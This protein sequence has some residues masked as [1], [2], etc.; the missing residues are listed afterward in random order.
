M[1]L[2]IR[3]FSVMVRKLILVRFFRIE[4][5]TVHYEINYTDIYTCIQSS[6]D[7]ISLS[8]ASKIQV[9]GVPAKV[10]TPAWSEMISRDSHQRTNIAGSCVGAIHI[11]AKCSEVRKLTPIRA[12]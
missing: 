8:Q 1:K 10:A 11:I 9:E 6:W 3:K 12:R 5:L 4:R 7:Q 2:I